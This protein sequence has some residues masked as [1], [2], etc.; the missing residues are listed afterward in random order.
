MK[1]MEIRIVPT[2]L[3]FLEYQLLRKPVKNVNLRIDREGRIR[4]SAAPQVPTSF[5]DDFV[6]QKE[7]FILKAIESIQKRKADCE[8]PEDG[9]WEAGKK[10]PVLGQSFTL[11]IQE[12]KKEGITLKAPYLYL[13]VK[14]QAVKERKEAIWQAWQRSLAK[15]VLEES[16]E[17]IGNMVAPYGIVC[18]EMKLRRMTSRWGS[19]QPGKGKI[20]LNTRLVEAPVEAIDYVVLHELAHMKYPHHQPS[21]YEFIARFMPDWKERK[22]LLRGII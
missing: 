3:G 15:E 2:A 16:I 11:V 21:F 9:E 1:N 6:R 18:R 19:C 10:L 8:K 20:T 4:V 14:P 7:G 13:T 17:R 12:G 22:K 5:I